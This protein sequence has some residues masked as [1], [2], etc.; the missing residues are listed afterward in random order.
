MNVATLSSGEVMSVSFMDVRDFLEEGDI[1]VPRK[2]GTLVLLRLARK[3]P[4][5]KQVSFLRRELMC[6]KV[7]FCEDGRG[8][9]RV[10]QKRV[11]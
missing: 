10:S 7:P 2:G 4:R 11:A 6:P 3:G 5:V 9:A 8:D 1:F